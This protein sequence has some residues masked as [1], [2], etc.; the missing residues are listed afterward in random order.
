MTAAELASGELARLAQDNPHGNQ[1][2]QSPEGTV[3]LDFAGDLSGWAI[4][5]AGDCQGE[6]GA[7]S[8]DGEPLHCIQVGGCWQ[9]AMEGRPG[10]RLPRRIS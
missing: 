10:E 5:A 7:V 2:S 4:A 8:L 3:M 6:K 1:W 9:P